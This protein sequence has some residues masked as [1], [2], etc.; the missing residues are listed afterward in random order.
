MERLSATQ[1]KFRIVVVL[2]AFTTLMG[3]YSATLWRSSETG[4]DFGAYYTAAWLVRSHMSA[5]IYDV[6]DRNT[7]P[8]LH[9]ADPGTAY[10]Q[11]ARAHGVREA[12]LYLYPPTL[13]DLIVPLT[14][15]PTSA[16]IKVWH[17]LEV[18]LIAALSVALTRMLAIEFRG[19]AA[20]V[21]AGIL[22]FRPTLNTIH[23]GQVSIFLVFIMTVGLALYV[24]GYRILA[25]VLFALAVAIKLEPVIII[26]P[27]LAWRD[28]K[29]LR[30]L[31]AWGMILCMVLWTVNGSYALSLYFLH[32]LPAMSNGQL[33]GMAFDGNRSLG[34]ILYTVLDGASFHASPR[35]SA[36]LVRGISALILCYAGWLSRLRPDDNFASDRRF[37]TGLIFLLLMCCLSPYSWY[38]NWALSAP[39]VVMFCKRVWD[40]R[41]G[42]AEAVLLMALLLS[43]S[44]SRFDMAM[45]TPVVGVALGIVGL[46]RMRI[47][48][49]D[50]KASCLHQLSNAVASG[51]SS[52][53]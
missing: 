40:G 20:L 23:W 9:L 53:P 28:W 7:N 47:E 25:A 37:E 34:N 45:I 48:Q 5:H 52:H 12:V 30:S 11:S 41:A 22:F 36:W 32:Q 27:L 4:V 31:A 16:A 8:Q 46:H 51:A 35:V 18:L 3:V 42:T 50:A 13:A 49:R 2:V 29:F 15:L 21:F 39:A 24:R 26:V 14:A 6:I 17:A 10:A 43:L 33:G 19:S 1:V 38:Y 44:T